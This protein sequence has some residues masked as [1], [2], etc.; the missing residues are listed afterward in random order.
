LPFFSSPF[1]T[2]F[3]FHRKTLFP[4]V[5]P[6]V[7]ISYSGF[8]PF[9]SPPS[10]LLAKGAPPA[11]SPPHFFFSAGSPVEE[12]TSG[13]SS[14]PPD[15]AFFWRFFLF[16][17]LFPRPPA[18]PLMT[19]FSSLKPSAPLIPSPLFLNSVPPLRRDQRTL[20]TSSPKRQTRNP[21]RS[22]RYILPSPFPR[23]LGRHA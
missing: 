16:S 9:C 11:P 19:W 10:P 23:W 12:S 14:P 22:S 13:Y 21:K 3:F 17:V 1:F 18:T 6:P 20:P 5:P 8:L 4:F 2:L 15:A 7:L